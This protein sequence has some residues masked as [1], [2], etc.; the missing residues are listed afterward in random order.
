METT[1]L[2]QSLNETR[3]E[4]LDEAFKSFMETLPIKE[5]TPSLDDNGS[6]KNLNNDVYTFSKENEIYLSYTADVNIEIGLK[7]IGNQPYQF[8][9]IDTWNMRITSKEDVQPGEFRYTTKG[10][11]EAVYLSVKK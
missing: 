6:P 7:L 5:M 9:I 4:I 10:K 8:K 3:K 2:L 1:D 11:Y